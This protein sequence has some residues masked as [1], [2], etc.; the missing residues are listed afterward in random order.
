MSQRIKELQAQMEVEQEAMRQEL[1]SAD[2]NGNDDAVAKHTA[3]NVDLRPSARTALDAEGD[4][5]A[6][7]KALLRKKQQDQAA[8][9]SRIS[10]SKVAAIVGVVVVVSL[11][12]LLLLFSNDSRELETSKPMT[13]TELK[14]NRPD[15][16][17]P[18]AWWIPNKCKGM[19]RIRSPS[20]QRECQEFFDK[21]EYTV[22]FLQKCQIPIKD[23]KITDEKI[24]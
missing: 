16:P 3:V 8:E 5:M 4:E 11:L 9:T 18:D 7:R 20:V 24:P 14:L 19:K 10:P 22:E 21:Y 2:G 15:N 23:G 17:C 13:L 12:L 1:S 6:E